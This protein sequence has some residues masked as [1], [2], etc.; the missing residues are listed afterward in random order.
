MFLLVDKK[1]SIWVLML[2]WIHA[3]HVFSNSFQVNIFIFDIYREGSNTQTGKGF[4]IK[5]LNDKG[6]RGI[7]S[8]NSPL[9][10]LFY[11]LSDF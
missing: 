8:E 4:G 10:E 1:S 3:W 7:K 11:F 5:I 6:S 2:N 9:I